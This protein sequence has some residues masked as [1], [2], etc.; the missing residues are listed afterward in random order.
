[1]SILSKLM[2]TAQNAAGQAGRTRST[3]R[4][5]GRSRGTRPATGAGGTA[6]GLGAIV[7][8]LMSNRRR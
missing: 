7:T 6:G 1:M 4:P 8:K 2:G 5:A 3:G